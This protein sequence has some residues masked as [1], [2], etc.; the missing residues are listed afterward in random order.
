[1]LVMILCLLGNIGH[2][3][4]RKKCKKCKGHIELG[5]CVEGGSC[6]CETFASGFPSGMGAKVGGM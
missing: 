3:Q 4:L 5:M 1:M 2:K 6:S